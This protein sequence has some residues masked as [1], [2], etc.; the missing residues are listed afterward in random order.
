M[1]IIEHDHDADKIA[2]HQPSFTSCLIISHDYQ[3][4][5]QQRGS[6]WPTYPDYISAFGGR[7]EAGET[8]TE[9]IIRELQ[10]ELGAQVTAAELHYLG[11]VTEASSK[12][13]EM[14]FGFIW[15]DKSNTITGCY[16]GEIASFTEVTT[17]LAKSKLLDDIPWLIE[18][19]LQANLLSMVFDSKHLNA[20]LKLWQQESTLSWQNKLERSLKY[21]SN[22]WQLTRIKP[23]QQLSYHY[24]AA[25]TK[26]QDKKAV[27]KIGFDHDSIKSEHNA[28]THFNGNGSI[29]CLDYNNK[30]QALLLQQA[31]PGQSVYCSF[32]ENINTGIKNYAKLAKRIKNLTNDNPEL[33]KHTNDLLTAIDEIDSTVFSEKQLQLAKVLRKEI[34]KKR[35]P[36]YLCHGDLHLGNIVYHNNDWISIDP[37]GIIGN[38]AFEAAACNLLT[39]TEMTQMNH[40]ELFA[41]RAEKLA[42]NLNL[43]N[44][45]LLDWMYLRAVLAVQWCIEDNIDTKE[46]MKVLTVI[47]EILT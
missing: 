23:Y 32:F 17:V 7:I 31:T 45:T 29:K 36:E 40:L 1:N 3:L 18:K 34:T 13:K 22:Q 2:S 35:L 25:A 33:F 41:S 8:P 16:E 46:K 14:V 12:H 39:D 5:L 21:L 20:N 19:S 6:D 27:L 43:D 44:S 10:E 28:L 37:K 4:L 15:H 11:A 42:N 47:S 26:D 9:G 30:H 24:V 38:L